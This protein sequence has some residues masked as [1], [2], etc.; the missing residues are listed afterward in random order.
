MPLDFGLDAGLAVLDAANRSHN[1][2]EAWATKTSLA[3]VHVLGRAM[4]RLATA[5]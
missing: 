3:G 1:S 2:D 4:H 5:R